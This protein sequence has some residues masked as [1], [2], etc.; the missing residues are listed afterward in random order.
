MDDAKKKY[1]LSEE[2]VKNLELMG[3][4]I[5]HIIQKLDDE[6]FLIKCGGPRYVVNICPKLDV[7][8]PKP[9]TRIF[10]DA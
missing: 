10:R 4:Q 3:S 5:G 8:K 2:K 9:G 1:E 7:S 6:T